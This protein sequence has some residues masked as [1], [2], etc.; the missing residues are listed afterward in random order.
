MNE[1]LWAGVE[2]KVQYAEFHLQQMIRSLQPPERTPVNVPQQTAGA[3]IDTGWQRSFY[4]H[5]DAFLSTARSVPEII[6]CCF[7]EDR[8]NRANP[9]MREWWNKLPAEERERRKEFRKQFT[10]DYDSFR[11]LR[12]ST[13]R[14][15]SEHRIG[16]ASVTVTI[17]GLFGVIYDGGPVRRVPLS[18]TRDIADP[19]L[20][21]LA[22]P[23]PLQPQWDDFTIDGQKLFPACQDYLARAQALVVEAR[24]HVLQVH[25]TDT[26]TPPPS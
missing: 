16:Y 8:A 20:A 2:L 5:F 1:A 26:L 22:K 4:A 25:G 13:A 7:G 15:I 17:S 9:V 10:S 12:L 6:Q 19:Q 18:E 14:H 24:R 21:V 3:I 23:V 11:A